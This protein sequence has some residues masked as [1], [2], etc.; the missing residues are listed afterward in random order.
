MKLKTFTAL[1]A[2]AAAAFAFTGCTGDEPYNGEKPTH[3]DKGGG[4]NDD[5]GVP[6][7]EIKKVPTLVNRSGFVI[8]T[9]APGLIHYV[10]EGH[11]PVT[12][13]NQYINVIELDLTSGAH[14]LE[15]AYYMPGDNNPT[16]AEA[17]KDARGIVAVNAG[18]EPSSINIR[19]N[20]VNLWWT[21][22]DPADEIL[23][24]R[25]NAAIMWND[26]SDVRIVNARKDF[27]Q[28]NDCYKDCSEKNLISS[29][30]MIIDD[31]KLVGSQIVNPIY[32]LDDLRNMD[33]GM[34]DSF[35][36][37]RHPRTIAALTDDRDLLLFTFDGRAKEAEGIN[38]AEAARFIAGNFNAQYA[39]NMDGGGSTTMCIKGQGD[40]VTNCVNHP[41]DNGKFDH[42]GLR[43]LT[44]FFII[45]PN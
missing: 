25:H 13:A 9:I 43:S 18:L 22:V 16:A 30:P 2:I 36:G 35:S 12:Q 6:G 19:R 7:A 38:M 27:F 37:L 32:T 33:G 23:G 34:L 24:W 42:D 28:C 4:N 15:L 14:R 29:G 20:G 39:L 41:T 21:S 45:V 11:E 8:D 31:Y 44:T 1:L 40:P 26:I 5:P 3:H 10:Y 17:M